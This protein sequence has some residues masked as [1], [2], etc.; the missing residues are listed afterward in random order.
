MLQ[1]CRL[2]RG[3][4]AFYRHDRDEAGTRQRGPRANPKISAGPSRY[5]TCAESVFK[6][7]VATV[8]RP[9]G[10]AFISQSAHVLASVAT[11]PFLNV[12][13][14][15]V[16]GQFEIA[17]LTSFNRVGNAPRVERR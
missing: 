8:V 13:A 6:P 16:M 4:C 10:L 7:K 1:S 12:D 3:R 5:K 15:R 2:S 11:R 17:A 14:A 9:W